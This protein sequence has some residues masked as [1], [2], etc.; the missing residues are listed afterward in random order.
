MSGL[1]FQMLSLRCIFGQHIQDANVSLAKHL[2]EI[3]LKM[4]VW[5]LPWNCLTLQHTKSLWPVGPFLVISF[6]L[7]SVI[8]TLLFAHESA[9]RKTFFRVEGLVTY[10]ARAPAAAAASPAVAAALLAAAAFEFSFA[11][12][13][14]VCIQKLV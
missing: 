4:L 8:L 12:A 7:S 13:F 9:G 2:D 11:L 14:A 10:I 1:P 6:F 3:N 5:L